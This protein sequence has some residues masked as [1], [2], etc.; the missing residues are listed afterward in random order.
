MSLVEQFAMSREARA[1]LGKKK[2][3]YFGLTPIARGPMLKQSELR[4][5]RRA[6]HL[7]KRLSA[8]NEETL[9][10]ALGQ[11]LSPGSSSATLDP[12]A[13]ISPDDWLQNIFRVDSA[14]DNSQL[15][16]RYPLSG[17]RSTSWRNLDL[18]RTRKSS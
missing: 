17:L 3:G 16:I 10:I 2:T 12:A 7:R 13:A 6:S 4:K 5:R 18:L 14:F 11:A 9:R 8:V 1:G 15:G